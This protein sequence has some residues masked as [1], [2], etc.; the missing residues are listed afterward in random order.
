LKA[1]G[2]TRPGGENFFWGCFFNPIFYFS[3]NL[4]IISALNATLMQF[5]YGG[6]DPGG[7]V[8]VPMVFAGFIFTVIQT[9][10]IYRYFSPP[11]KETRFK[12]LRDPRSELIG[13]IC[14]FL[15]MILFQSG[16]IGQMQ[17]PVANVTD[18]S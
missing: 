7:A 12:F 4:V 2:K 13:D 6:K 3:L 5:L 9:W 1:A 14:I 15:N 11:K 8:F 17:P 18:F 16:T 10:L